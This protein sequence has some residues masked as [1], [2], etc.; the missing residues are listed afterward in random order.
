[1]RLVVQYAI[2]STRGVVSCCKSRAAL[3]ACINYNVTWVLCQSEPTFNK[4]NV[5]PLRYLLNILITPE[6]IR[7]GVVANG[8]RCEIIAALATRILQHDIQPS[9]M[10]QTYLKVSTITGS[11]SK[12]LCKFPD[13]LTL[14]LWM[15]YMHYYIAG[16][17]QGRK[18]SWIGKRDYFAK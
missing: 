4:I 5:P 9:S 2:Y 16:N 15:R 10:Y 14:C 17:F 6:S 7:T 18:L 11:R 13:L 12:W 3:R 8:A 1:M